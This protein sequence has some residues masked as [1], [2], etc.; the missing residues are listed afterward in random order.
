[1][2]FEICDFFI[3]PAYGYLGQ[4][5]EEGD[6]DALAYEV[7]FEVDEDDGKFIFNKFITK[8]SH[9]NESD[10]TDEMKRQLE[11]IVND[12]YNSFEEDEMCDYC[13]RPGKY[14]C[15]P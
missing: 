2:E 11:K 8:P 7:Q 13:R 3:S 1:M 4:F 10:L 14:C 12:R 5:T 9:F 15:C 6:E